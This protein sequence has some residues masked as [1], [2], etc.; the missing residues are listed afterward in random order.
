MHLTSSP[1]DWYAARAAGVVAYVLL[2]VV[3]SLGLTLSSKRRLERWPRFAL[4]EVHRFGGILVGVFIAIHVVTIA[5]D[6]FLRF[7]IASILVP[8][9]SSYRTVWVALGIVAAELLLAL[10]VTNRLRDRIG[11]ARWRVFHYANFAVWTAATLHGLASG[12]DRS[13]SWLVAIQAV[14]VALVGALTAARF[15]LPERQAY[16]AGAAAGALAVVLALV[17]FPFHPKP[18]NARVFHDRLTG[19]ISRNAGPTRELVSVAA[20]GEGDQKVLMRADLLVEPQGLLTTSFQLEFLPSGMRCVGRVTRVD[21]LGFEGVCRAADGSTRVVDA[22]WEAELGAQFN[23][24][25]LD[26]H[27]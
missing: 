24:G 17:V 5:I 23:Q 9:V 25:T 8:F 12:T 13:T 20:T 4:E 14:A 16:G 15:R 11:Y 10:A 6:S 26:V 18:W 19:V 2:T 3:V 21:Q 7:S 22:A 27:A 1:V